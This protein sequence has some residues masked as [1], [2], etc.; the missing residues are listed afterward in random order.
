MKQTNLLLSAGVA[1]AVLFWISTAICG[2]V[3][4]NYD[5]L[6]DT[7]SELGA[8]GT[9]SKVVFSVLL[10]TVALLGI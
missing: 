2:F 4:G 5:H 9:R 1:A 6:H 3:H 8:L 10:Q 7:I